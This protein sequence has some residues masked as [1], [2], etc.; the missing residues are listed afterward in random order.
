MCIRDRSSPAA[1]RR[2][3]CAPRRRPCHGCRGGEPCWTSSVC[4]TSAVP[5]SLEIWGHLH[6]FTGPDSPTCVVSLLCTSVAVQLDG[7]HGGLGGKIRI[8]RTATDLHS[9]L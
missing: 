5:V 9:K 8:Y 7:D 6:V 3:G 2:P 4:S 1:P